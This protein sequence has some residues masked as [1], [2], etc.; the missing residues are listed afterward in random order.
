LEVLNDKEWDQEQDPGPLYDCVVFYDGQQFRALLIEVCYDKQQQQL[1]QKQ[2]VPLASFAVERQY[3]TFG[4]QDQYHYAVNFYE[5]GRILSIVR[6]SS[7]HGSHVASICSSIDEQ[8]QQSKG[9][10]GSSSGTSGEAAGPRRHGV[11][12]VC[13]ISYTPLVGACCQ[14]NIY[15][16]VHFSCLFFISPHIKLT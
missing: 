6:D 12:P 9:G 16:N 14:Q 4:V 2:L 13:I 15:S 7:P 8:Q 5:N 10:V 1:Q 11:A 3:G